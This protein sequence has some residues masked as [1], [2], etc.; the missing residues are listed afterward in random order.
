MTEIQF[1]RGLTETSIPDVKLTRSKDGTSGRA[2]FYFED[3]LALSQEAKDDPTGMY[4]ID[5]EGELIT[6]KVN[7]KFINGRPAA[8]EAFYEMTSAAEWD[9]FIRFMERYGEVNGLGFQK[10]E[11]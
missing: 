9:R 1:V 6:R 8:L 4:M 5:E 2:V 11:S 7:A 3:P 10:A